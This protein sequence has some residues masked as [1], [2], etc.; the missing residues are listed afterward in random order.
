MDTRSCD[1]EVLT[2]K[3]RP[4]RDV[5][6]DFFFVVFCQLGDHPGVHAV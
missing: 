5:V 1:I 2:D 4:G 3:R 6:A